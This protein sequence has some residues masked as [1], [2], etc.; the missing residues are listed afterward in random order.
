MSQDWRNFIERWQR[1]RPEGVLRLPGPFSPRFEPSA[2]IM[3]LERAGRH[4]LVIF[5]SVEGSAMPVVAN[6]LASRER[7]AMA[8]K[9]ETPELAETF[10]RRI[11]RAL[12]PEEL[13]EPPF[14]ANSRQGVEMDLTRLPILTHFPV[15][16]GPYITAGLVVARDPRTG[17]DTMGYH[18]MQLKGPDRL[19]VSLH[20]RQRLWEYHRRAE[21]AGEN[22]PAAV[23]L[24][25]HPAVSLGS[26]ALVPYEA[27]KF[28]RVGG[29]FGEPMQIARCPNTEVS[30]PAWA[31]IV[32]EGEILAGAREPE[33]PF[34]EFTGYAS[35][36]STENV[37]AAKALH[38]R[39]GAMYQSITPAMT[40]DHITIV[41]VHREGEALRALRE[42][43]PNVLAVH[44]PVSSC[45]LFHL[46][47]SIKKTAEG[48][49]MQA[50]LAALGL[51]HNIKHV[52]VVDEDVDVSDEAQVLW[53][54]A[55][56]VQADRDVH[57]VP[58]HLGMGCTLDP[59]T[60]EQSRTARMGIDATK[61]C[62][63]FS[64]GIDPDPAA[65]E[66]ARAVLRAAG[67]PAA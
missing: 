55:T 15:D 45:G 24:G 66:R 47:V 44:A 32:I 58:Q 23:V 46:Y 9:V 3:E 26:M 6:L 38:W 57:I 36:R 52:V 35:Y 19:G 18:R 41:A 49:P 34:A 61:P 63:G 27:G 33:G 42:T 17:A 62:S 65:Q 11:K 56:R 29:L 51:D 2:V 14:M 59:S 5:E 40:A 39:E 13:A 1:L 8:L 54:V 7:L 50:V 25:V 22:L 67:W 20:S 31:E 28:A 48:Q 21:E 43:L 60:D 30:V 4:P 37:F 64:P 16:A 53:A 12:E 10:A